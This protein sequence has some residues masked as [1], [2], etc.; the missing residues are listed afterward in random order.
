MVNSLRYAQKIAF[1]LSAL[2]FSS[3]SYSANPDILTVKNKQDIKVVYD[4]NQNNIQAGIGKGLYYVRGLLQAYQKQ[5]VSNKQLHISVVV[6]GAAA[7]WLLK[8]KPY[9]KFTG[10][11]FDVNANKKVV[12][13]LLGLGVSVEICHVTMKG[14]G[15]TAE[16]VLP[17]VK[18]VFDAYTR[19][20]DL[21]Q[22][23]YA[24]IKFF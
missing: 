8:D 17:G 9:Q 2:L 14:Y 1:L 13:D 16:D 20:I 23:G 24:Y 5:G 3:L 22:Q 21:Q 15:W 4:I 12:Q 11:P 10:N 6:H 19:M 18:L 7:Y